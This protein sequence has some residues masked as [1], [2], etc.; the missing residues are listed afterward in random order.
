VGKVIGKAEDGALI[1]SF[2]KGKHLGYV[3]EI[4]YTE[5]VN[6]GFHFSTYRSASYME[7]YKMKD[8]K[9]ENRI[10]I[11]ILILPCVEGYLPDHIDLN[12]LNNRLCNL[13]PA[14]NAE[15][16]HNKKISS[17]NTSGYKGVVWNKPNNM[18]KA[19]IKM[20]GKTHYLGYYTT[21]EEAFNAYANAAF[22]YH[23]EFARLF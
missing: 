5:L 11:H 23:G 9:K 15:N 16:M 6:K 3:D 2:N 20:Q 8:G 13:R 21:P 14:T 17:I 22:K 19:H 10:G 18:W 4:I 12:G 7:A 1:M